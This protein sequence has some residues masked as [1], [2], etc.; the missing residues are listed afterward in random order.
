MFEAE[1][2]CKSSGLPAEVIS[3]N[4]VIGLAQRAARMRRR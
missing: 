2:S 3:R 4:A 1:R